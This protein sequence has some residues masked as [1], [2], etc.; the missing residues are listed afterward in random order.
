[1]SQVT[2]RSHIAAIL[3]KLRVG[4]R[5]EALRLLEERE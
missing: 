5:E 3:K 1:V 2:V 4:S